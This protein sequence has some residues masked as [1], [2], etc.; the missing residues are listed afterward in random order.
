MG[1][2]LL[3]GLDFLNVI[4]ENPDVYS[5]Y[6]RSLKASPLPK[7]GVFGYK[8]CAARARAF[9]PGMCSLTARVL[10]SSSP[11]F[12]SCCRP[13][14]ARVPVLIPCLIFPCRRSPP[15]ALFLMGP[16]GLAN[17]VLVALLVKQEMSGSNQSPS[18]FGTGF[19]AFS[20]WVIFWLSGLSG[21]ASPLLVSGV[22][23]KGLLPSCPL[24]SYIL[25]C[26]TCARCAARHVLLPCCLGV[27]LQ[28]DVSNTQTYFWSHNF[29]FF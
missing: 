3:C 21:P 25:C 4:I 17:P 28:L 8:S 29:N 18:A 10:P 5:R 6:L 13:S 23:W 12:A 22:I 19:A 14:R 7:P 24:R 27:W 26:F 9:T 15:C 2:V 20:L 16:G 11:S 1:D